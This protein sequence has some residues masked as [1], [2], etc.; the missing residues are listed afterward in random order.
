MKLI[1]QLQLQLEAQL[2]HTPVSHV[3]LFAEGVSTTPTTT[4]ESTSTPTKSASTGTPGTCTSTATSV[5][6]D[7]R[8]A[9]HGRGWG[10]GGCGERVV[11]MGMVTAKVNT[12]LNTMIVTVERDCLRVP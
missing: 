8:T 3:V 6:G 2:R 1:D 11:V 10:G 5:S 4:A 7:G 12:Q 9:E